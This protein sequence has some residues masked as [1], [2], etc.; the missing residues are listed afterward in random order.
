MSSLGL[1]GHGLG[2]MR[3]GL[4]LLCVIDAGLRLTQATLMYSDLGVLPRD[5]A[6]RFFEQSYAVSLYLLSGQPLFV[7]LLLALTAALGG[8]NLAGKSQRRTRVLLWFL[9][10]SVQV[11]NPA[12]TDAADHLLRLLLFWDMF[13]PDT[14]PQERLRSVPT[15]GLQSQLTLTLAAVA[16]H[17]HSSQGWSLAAQWGDRPLAMLAPWFAQLEAALLGLAVVAVWVVGLR[18]WLLGP[19]LL[20]LLVW[21]ALMDPS[22]PVTLGVGLLSLVG[23]TQAPV[24]RQPWEKGPLCAVVVLLL[25]G[26]C[27]SVLG[28]DRVPLPLK[29][30]GETVGMNQDWKRVYPLAQTHRHQIEV[31]AQGRRLTLGQDRRT[32]LYVQ[33]AGLD[34]RF[35]EPVAK[36][37]LRDLKFQGQATIW[38]RTDRFSAQLQVQKGR[39]ERLHQLVIKTFKKPPR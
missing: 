25:A 15:L 5:A 11:R 8:L 26:V 24:K 13:L 31:E 17:H 7:M 28:S 33:R 32:R 3:K 16:Y 29:V 22:F 1:H 10:I 35:A 36:A 18:R 30:V 38:R 4:G 9:V 23:P 37:L 6:Y 21:A 12:L 19:I 39:P 34:S 27:S 2:L 20:C 14:P